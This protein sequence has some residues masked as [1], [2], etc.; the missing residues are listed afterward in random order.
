MM[1]ELIKFLRQKYVVKGDFIHGS[2]RHLFSAAAGLSSEVH[3]AGK[4]H[5]PFLFVNDV[6]HLKEVL[7][8]AQLAEA[9]LAGRVADVDQL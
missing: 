7:L 9:V 6:K 2:L 1:I 5:E 4:V 3:R 8:H